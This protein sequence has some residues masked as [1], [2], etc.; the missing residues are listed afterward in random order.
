MAESAAAIKQI[1]FMWEG[2]DRNGKRVKGKLVAASEAALRAELRRQ[3]V[4]P[5][6]IRKQTNLFKPRSRVTPA[7]I[8]IFSRQLATMME[9]GIPIVQAFDIVGTG[10]ENPA[11]QKLILTI[12][13]EE[14][15]SE[16]Q[17]RENL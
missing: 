14:H 8:A 11:M 4:V 10:H 6:R 2:T 5:T 1:P 13:S 3:G 7:D 17:S 15:T 12:R 9:A 16:L